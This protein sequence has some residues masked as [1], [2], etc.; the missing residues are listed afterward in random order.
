MEK[1]T[2]LTFLKSFTGG[3]KGKMTKYINMIL[4]SGPSSI[5]LMEEHLTN[6]DWP[7]LRTAAH[8]IKPQMSYMG[9]KK[10]EELARAIESNAGEQVNLENIPLQIN[11]FKLLFEKASEELKTEL[12]N[13]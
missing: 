9:A 8:S 6:K 7:Q 13:F 3:D 1:I 4:N 11:E 5:R 12:Q 10:A 2:D